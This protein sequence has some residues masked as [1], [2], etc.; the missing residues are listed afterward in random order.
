MDES[1]KDFFF[2]GHVYLAVKNKMIGQLFTIFS[3]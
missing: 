1:M 3:F 2:G